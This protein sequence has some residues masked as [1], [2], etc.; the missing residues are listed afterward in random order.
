MLVI[1]AASFL[2]SISLADKIQCLSAT[3]IGSSSGRAGPA[4][5]DDCIALCRHINPYEEIDLW[6]NATFRESCRLENL[7]VTANDV[8]LGVNSCFNHKVHGYA[9]FYRPS[10]TG[11]AHKWTET[12][13]QCQ[14]WCQTQPAC[15]SWIWMPMENEQQGPCFLKSVMQIDE[16]LSTV[17]STDELP[18]QWDYN[19]DTNYCPPN[20]NRQC[21]LAS[22]NC[23][24]VDGS[25][26][27]VWLNPKVVAG[28]KFCDVRAEE[29]VTALSYAREKW[30][31]LV[32]VTAP[33][34]AFDEIDIATMDFEPQTSEPSLNELL[35]ALISIKVGITGTTRPATTPPPME[36]SST[37][38]LP[39]TAPTLVSDITST[40]IISDAIG[41]STT[42][43]VN[44]G[45]STTALREFNNSELSLEK[46]LPRPLSPAE[47]TIS[48]YCRR[49]PWCCDRVSPITIHVE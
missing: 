1:F 20:L 28:P 12:P 7:K 30:S 23:I 41:S 45:S 6:N 27:C 35:E 14:G 32:N 36:I 38:P 40:S 33:A 16:A 17:L 25:P 11:F 37:T 49:C 26:R 22:H 5:T 34:D 24:F 15:I 13:S 10:L 31:I 46:R 42:A 8:Q 3:Y 43:A 21:Y 48:I 39:M 44:E 29:V 9:D 4:S 18:P 47:K 19:Y 2:W